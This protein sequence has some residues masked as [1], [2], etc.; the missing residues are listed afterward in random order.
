MN[1]KI[2]TATAL[3]VISLLVA[4]APAAASTRSLLLS[5][6]GG[7]GA[8]EQAI[9]CSTLLNV[10]RGGAGGSGGSGG[11]G[12]VTSSAAGVGIAVGA[13]PLHGVASGIGSSRSSHSSRS[14]GAQVDRAGARPHPSPPGSVPTGSSAIGLSSGDTLLLTGTILALALIGALTVRL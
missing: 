9:I 4:S 1:R 8:G 5:G 3:T 7:P 11:A 2:R 10:P 13:A 14:N 6:Y 12:G